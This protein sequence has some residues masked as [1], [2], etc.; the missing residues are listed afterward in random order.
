MDQRAVRAPDEFTPGIAENTVDGIADI[1]R[2]AVFV[3]DE[4]DIPGIFDY[5]ARP[6]LIENLRFLA[7]P[8]SAHVMNDADDF[9]YRASRPVT[10]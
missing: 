8:V 7:R 1:E 5:L 6:S 4:D 9:R 10:G 3:H 2:P